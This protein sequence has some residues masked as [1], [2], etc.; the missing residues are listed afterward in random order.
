MKKTLLALG[1]LLALAACQSPLQK[2]YSEETFDEDMKALEGEIDSTE[3]GMIFGTIMA[4]QL[5]GKEVKGNTY[6]EL[7]KEGKEIKAK[8]EKEEAE[9]KALAEKAA[10]E[11]AERLEKLRAATAVTIFEKD[12]VEVDYQ[13]FITMKFVIKNKSDKEIRAMK[14][15]IVF[16]NLFDEEIK[17]V[18]FMYDQQIE[19]GGEIVWDASLEYNQFSSEDKTLRSKDLK[20][21]KVVW[22]PEK[23]MFS[24]GTSLE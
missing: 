4:R 23:I 5:E 12:Y 6:E 22:K 20:D 21:I 18:N 2:Q 11:E 1:I 14:G 8:R 13:D 10:R 15:V 19:A 9:Q 3:L 16:N 24:D 17:S 7:L